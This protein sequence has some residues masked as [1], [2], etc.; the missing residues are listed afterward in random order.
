MKAIVEL[1]IS[2][3]KE[4]ELKKEGY[5]MVYENTFEDSACFY[6]NLIKVLKEK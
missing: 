2:L 4:K 1:E 5:I 6:I 3:E